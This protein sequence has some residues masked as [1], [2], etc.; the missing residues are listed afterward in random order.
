MV[1]YSS[2]PSL[3]TPQGMPL[4]AVYQE[5]VVGIRYQ[6]PRIAPPGTTP[7][8][9]MRPILLYMY[10]AKR[11]QY[12]VAI[13]PFPGGVRQPSR[14]DRIHRV[15]SLHLSMQSQRPASSPRRA[16]G[17]RLT[18]R[19]HSSAELADACVLPSPSYRPTRPQA[20]YVGSTSTRGQPC[21]CDQACGDDAS[22]LR[23]YARRGLELGSPSGA[24]LLYT[25]T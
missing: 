2:L 1:A 17:V 6:H 7:V 20:S 23:Y 5:G 15:N 9:Y 8:G 12:I 24:V 14:S 16:A 25:G 4:K 19:I 13:P 18:K 22:V 3:Q 21:A 11:Y 10:S